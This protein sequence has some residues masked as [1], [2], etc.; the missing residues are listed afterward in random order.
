[1]PHRSERAPMSTATSGGAS[2]SPSGAALISPAVGSTH[3]Q[4]WH[5][6]HSWNATA[7]GG[8]STMAQRL[9][10]RQH[11]CDTR[12]R[13]APLPAEAAAPPPSPLGRAKCRSGKLCGVG[14][15]RSGSAAAAATPDAALPPPPPLPAPSAM[16]MPAPERRRER[17][18][19][20]RRH[21]Q[22]NGIK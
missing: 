4:V 8:C 18:H 9:T 5:V 1:M 10:R 2:A 19:R 7:A 6:P 17:R 13:S 20:Q 12:E 22:I 3:H 14:G 21:L 15:S 11:L 16:G